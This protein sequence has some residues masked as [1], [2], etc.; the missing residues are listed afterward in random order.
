[1]A[2]FYRQSTG[3]VDYD[4]RED[5]VALAFR[6]FA[7]PRSSTG[8]GQVEPGAAGRLQRVS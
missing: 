3:P 7:S 8:V 1:M 5:N 4:Q 2:H 6:W